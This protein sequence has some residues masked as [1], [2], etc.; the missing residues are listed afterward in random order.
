MD[1]FYERMEDHS[2]AKA[3]IVSK[4]FWA[5][6]KIML[7]R[8]PSKR[9]AYIDLF[10]GK[11]RYDDGRKSTPLLV[12]EKAIADPVLRD[13]LVTIFN[14]VNPEYTKILEEEIKALPGIEQL[15]YRP[16]VS[17]IEVGSKVAELFEG[18]NLVPSLVFVD[19]WGYKGLS[20]RLLNAFT[21]NWGC[22]C[23]FFFNYNRINPGL[24]NEVVRDHMVALFGESRLAKLQSRVANL[25]PQQR[26]LVI[27]NEL[28]EGIRGSGRERIE[29]VLPFRFT[30]Q[31][32]RR[33][34]LVFVS[35]SPLGCK[36]MK[37]IMY[38]A[39]TSHE[40]GVASFEYTPVKDSQLKLL[41]DYARPLDTL[42]DEL[43]SV[44]AGQTLT[45][46][47]IYERHNVGRR[48]V[49]ANYQEALK[50]LEAAGRIKVDPPR[51]TRRPGTLPKTARITFP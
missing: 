43:L 39:S 30:T 26:E 28:A 15:R 24:N 19:P 25:S 9:I 21:K 40:D 13:G 7:P 44:F 2:E 50:R 46:A 51:D 31:A 22:E 12:L 34:Y 32:G 1:G 10:A 23:I 14:D 4:Y 6:A 35:K 11:G 45:V 36:I 49:L 33:Y 38:K 16:A 47:E 3:T 17:S 8:S 5:W 37:D 29:Y 27:V 20:L 48:F 18:L 41:F 42:G